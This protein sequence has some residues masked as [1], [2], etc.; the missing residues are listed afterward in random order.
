MAT[1]MLATA[2]R[3]GEV[4]EVLL[5]V[6]NAAAVV[7]AVDPP[8]NRRAGGGKTVAREATMTTVVGTDGKR[9]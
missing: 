8:R 3:V 4:V 2:E 7:R 5:V 1:A 6:A 9:D